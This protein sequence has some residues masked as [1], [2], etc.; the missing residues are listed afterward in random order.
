MLLPNAL[1]KHSA[2]S[3]LPRPPKAVA[4]IRSSL[5]AIGLHIC[6]Q[7]RRGN[8]AAHRLISPACFL[9]KYSSFLGESKPRVHT[10]QKRYSTFTA[11]SHRYL[12]W[13][14]TDKRLTKDIWYFVAG[15]RAQSLAHA[16]Q[17]LHHAQ[18][19]FPKLCVM[20]MCIWRPEERSGS[21]LQYYPPFSRDR[22]YLPAW[23]LPS[24]LRWLAREPEESACL[25]CLSPGIKAHSSMSS[26]WW[27]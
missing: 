27:W 7:G 8:T 19:H 1:K 18:L 10:N 22:V 23:D 13:E 15:H 26:L 12:R 6:H 21:F 11:A 17:V 9:V 24:T 14:M 4:L 5:P 2:I 3:S 16:K 25:R 20:H